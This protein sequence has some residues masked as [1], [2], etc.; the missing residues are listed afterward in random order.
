MK[1]AIYWMIVFILN[2]MFLS[3][4]GP[5]TEAIATMTA[6]AWTPTPEPTPIPTPIPYDLEVYLEDES[7]NPVTKMAYVDVKELETDGSAVDDNGNVEF[8]DLPGEFTL[9]L[10][11][12]GYN[13]IEETVTLERG[14]NTK[15][16]SMQIDPL[17]LLPSE[18][19]QEGQEFLYLEDFEDGIAQGWVG[20]LVRPL[21][22]F[23]NMED[24]G[25]VLTANPS[26]GGE[27]YLD[28]PG[29]YENS[30]WHFNLLRVPGMGRVWMRL[31]R[32]EDQSYIVSIAGAKGL[33]TLDREP[34]VSISRR[35][36]KNN[37]GETWDNFSFAYFDGTIDI[38]ADD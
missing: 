30:V 27:L 18:V 20:N 13:S 28:L 32:N 34:G 4:C 15:I 38:W 6:S 3:A 7:G 5:S 24:R 22:D 25:T 17:Q 10:S 21:W 12:Q 37:D 8:L 26:A 9:A 35:W 29:I 14:L 36:L 23:E 31:H 2:L 1:K 16:Y 11:A 33:F 19:C